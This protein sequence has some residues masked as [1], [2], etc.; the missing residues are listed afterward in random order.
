MLMVTFGA[1]FGSTVMGRMSLFIDR[2]AFLLFD[3]L[4]LSPR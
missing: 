1:T 4:R 2:A 3:F